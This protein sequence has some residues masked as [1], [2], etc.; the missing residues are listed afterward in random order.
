MNVTAESPMNESIVLNKISENRIDSLGISEEDEFFKG[1][2]Q[3]ARY[4]E[5]FEERR[6]K[7]TYS[8]IQTEIDAYS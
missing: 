2:V 5:Q 4:Y 6:S 3:R 7:I 1:L 8:V